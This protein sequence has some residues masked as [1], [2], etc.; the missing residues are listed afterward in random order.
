MVV[1]FPKDVQALIKQP[2]NNY[3]LRVLKAV[4]A[5]NNDQKLVFNKIMKYLM[6]KENYCTLWS[7]F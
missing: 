4:E 6:S 5:V 1:L 3:E 7:F 2:V